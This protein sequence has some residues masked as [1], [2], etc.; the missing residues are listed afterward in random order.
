M[1]KRNDIYENVNQNN[2]D[3]DKLLVVFRWILCNWHSKSDSLDLRQWN[4]IETV[5]YHGFWIINERIYIYG[6][7][8]RLNQKENCHSFCTASP[9]CHLSIRLKGL[10]TLCIVFGAE[11]RK[12]GKF[13]EFVSSGSIWMKNTVKTIDTCSQFFCCMLWWNL[14]NSQLVFCIEIFRLFWIFYHHKR[15]VKATFANFIFIRYRHI[16]HA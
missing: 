4:W 16:F 9:F 10:V 13:M 1:I 14:S 7:I 3:C 6:R 5:I 12:N 11:Q 8:H 2:L 15:I